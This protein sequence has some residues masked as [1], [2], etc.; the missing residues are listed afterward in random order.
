MIGQESGVVDVR[1]ELGFV[2]RAAFTKELDA[3]LGRPCAWTGRWCWSRARP[4]SAKR[5]LTLDNHRLRQ[6]LEA[7]A[8]VTL[9]DTRH[10]PGP[11]SIRPPSIRPQ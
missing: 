10:R 1:D 4:G 9:I 7:T 3:S 11:S 6:Q 2:G 8:N 5:R